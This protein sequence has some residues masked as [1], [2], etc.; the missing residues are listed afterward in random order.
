[1]AAFAPS[2]HLPA[3]RWPPPR[4]RALHPPLG[5]SSPNPRTPPAPVRR[6]SADARRRRLTR[7]GREMEAMPEE[8]RCK[9]SDGKQWRCSAQGQ[10]AGRLLRAQG[11]APQ[12]LRRRKIPM[13]YD[14]T[15]FQSQNFQL[16][17]EDNSKFPSGLFQL[18]SS[19]LGCE[20]VASDQ[21]L[22]PLLGSCLVFIPAW[23]QFSRT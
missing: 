17:G 1:M 23:F 6:G 16:A 22:V 14:D 5:L 12:V 21:F 7:R 8:L 11:L 19:F 15:D 2:A 10:E 13:D 18:G 20:A 3:S 9:R 4:L